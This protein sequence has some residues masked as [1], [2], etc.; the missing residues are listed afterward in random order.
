MFV[1][2]KIG[3]RPRLH[4]R[5]PGI[6]LLKFFKVIFNLENQLPTLTN[7]VNKEQ[8]S[9]LQLRPIM[10]DNQNYRQNILTQSSLHP[11]HQKAFIIEEHEPVKQNTK[12][13][14]S[15]Q[16][17]FVLARNLG[18]KVSQIAPLAPLQEETLGETETTLIPSSSLSLSRFSTPH[19]PSP[20]SISFFT[21]SFENGENV[22]SIGEQPPQ[23]S[24][25]LLSS[26]DISTIDNNKFVKY[27]PKKKTIDNLIEAPTKPL[28]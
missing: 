13:I 25:K 21:R 11:F 15:S 26:P 17:N 4:I 8:L 20:P 18:T 27:L 5:R 22:G 2:K 12:K 3:Y 16:E 19:P 6:N 24:V 1:P 23:P 7:Q 10:Q 9:L 14:L 28:K